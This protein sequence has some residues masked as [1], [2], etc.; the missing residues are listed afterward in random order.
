MCGG[1]VLSVLQMDAV[2][3][4]TRSQVLDKFK[5][6]YDDVPL[7]LVQV[8]IVGVWGG[9]HMWGGLQTSH[10]PQCCWVGPR[11]GILVV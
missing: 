4:V 1:F 7:V 11:F 10:P 2:I 9:L 6:V 3:T 8:G 5:D